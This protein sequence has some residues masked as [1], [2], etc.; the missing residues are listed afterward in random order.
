LLFIAPPSSTEL[1]EVRGII[2]QTQVTR[3]ERSSPLLAYV[4]LNDFHLAQ[5]QAIQPPAWSQTLIEARGGPLLLA[6]QTGQRRVALLTFDLFQS[7]LPLQIDFPILLI[8]LTGWLLPEAAL[9]QGQSLRPQQSYNLPAIPATNSFTIK[10]PQGDQVTIPADQVA[11]VG[12]SELGI[13]RVLSQGD[14]SAESAHVAEF[15]VNL[16]A[17]TETDLQPRSVEFTGTAPTAAG[18]TLTGR[19]EWWWSLVLLGLGV[20]LVEW[21][22]YWRGASR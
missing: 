20:L 22:V 4:K 8:N 16:L 15:A 9:E 10:T 3:L 12:T 18:E 14:G 7:D 17:E 5:A 21:W 19:W 6:G 1:F 11:F 2:T 13:Y